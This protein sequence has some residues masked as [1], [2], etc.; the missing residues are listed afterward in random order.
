MNFLELF[1]SRDKKKRLSHIRNLMVLSLADGR[2]AKDEVDLVIKIGLNAGLTRE[3]LNRVISRPD[4]I[5]FSPP[6]TSRERIEQLY[7]MV[8]VMMVDGDIDE[9]EVNL[10]KIIANGL[11]FRPV[12]ID[13]MILE[14]I[15]VIVQGI[16]IDIAIER[17][18]RSA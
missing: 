13:K 7:D 6:E 15:D 5:N 9:N 17:L 4:S 18:L 3:E 14:V 12:I 16:A 10:C 2:L 8:M 1:D 11:G